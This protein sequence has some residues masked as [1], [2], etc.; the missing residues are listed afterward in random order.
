MKESAGEANITVI[1]IVLIG[2]V[3]AAGAIII[4]NL[5][6]STKTSSCCQSNGGV[7]YEGK[8]HVASDCTT[9]AKGTT[10]GPKTFNPTNCAS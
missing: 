1:T 3:A 9:S 10:C 5:L 6:N 4:P 7:W 2:L 8:C